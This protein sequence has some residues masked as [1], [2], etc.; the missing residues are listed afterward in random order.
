MTV[1][2]YSAGASILVCRTL[3]MPVRADSAWPASSPPP[4]DPCSNDADLPPFYGTP[5][6]ASRASLRRA[7]PSPLDDLEGLLYSL[8]SMTAPAGRD[9]RQTPHWLPYEVRQPGAR[10]AGPSG[11]AC[12][13]VQHQA[14]AN[15]LLGL[16]APCN[17]QCNL[18]SHKTNCVQTVRTVEVNGPWTARVMAIWATRK[19]A[20]WQMAVEQVGLQSTWLL[21]AL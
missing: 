10:A 12:L 14:D 20:G 13:H 15:R 16:V 4:D 19:E 2:A 9:G 11:S 21:L 18:P 7:P 17:G 6:Y 3:C 5:I 1:D 8:V